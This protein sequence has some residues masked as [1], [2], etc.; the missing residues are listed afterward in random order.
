MTSHEA[1]DSEARPVAK[2]CGERRSSQGGCFGRRLI[3]LLQPISDPSPVPM[4]PH[5]ILFVLFP[6]AKLI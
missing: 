5:H 2:G 3:R 4:V 1:L 6:S